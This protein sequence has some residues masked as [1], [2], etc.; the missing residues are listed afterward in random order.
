M[1]E[2]RCPY[3]GY[4]SLVNPLRETGYCPTHGRFDRSESPH[5]IRGDV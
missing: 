3:C 5:V 2:F 4:Y 1:Y